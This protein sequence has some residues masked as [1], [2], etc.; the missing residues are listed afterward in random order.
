MLAAM[1]RDSGKDGCNI[2]LSKDAAGAYF[3]DYDGSVRFCVVLSA[4]S[5]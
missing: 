1:F 4:A 2:G 5:P 3:V